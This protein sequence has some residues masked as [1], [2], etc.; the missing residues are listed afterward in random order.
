MIDEKKRETFKNRQVCKRKQMNKFF[1]DWLAYEKT[2][3][4]LRYQFVNI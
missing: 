2:T 4:E 1:L 3:F